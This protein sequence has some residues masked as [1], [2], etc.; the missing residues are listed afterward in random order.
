VL[1]PAAAWPQGEVM[2]QGSAI[3]TIMPKQNT[4]A[5]ASFAQD[6][7]KIEVNGKKAAI[8]GVTPLTGSASNPEIIV[9]IDSSARTSL[10]GQM[11]ELT[12]FIQGLPPNARV[13]VAYMENG[14]AVMATP[15]TDDRAQ[16]VKGLHLPGGSRGSNGGAYFCLSNL[17]QNWPSRMAQ[18]Q[19]EVVM[20]TD[21][22]DD[23]QHRFDPDDPYVKTAIDDAAKAHMVVYSIYWHDDGPSA[24]S[25]EEVN[26]G[27][28]LLAEVTDATGGRSYWQGFGNPISFEP[29]LGEIA[30]RLRNQYEIGFSAPFKG[31]PEVETMKLKLTA[32]GASVDA[33]RQV[34]IYPKTAVQ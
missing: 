10:G 16:V 9:L 14:R 23:Y 25:P 12:K 1:L 34:F 17:A 8:T 30:R 26:G 31:K 7:I 2:G 18:A 20:V 27:Q 13:G 33:P 11:N 19:R 24:R 6:S 15:L 3:V 32:P 4:D 22:I 5:P 29:F 28:S 21:G